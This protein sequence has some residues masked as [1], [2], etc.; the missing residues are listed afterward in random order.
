[1]FKAMRT[2]ENDSTGS[3]TGVKSQMA[4]IN[5]ANALWLAEDALK[6]LHT[7]LKAIPGQIHDTVDLDPDLNVDIIEPRE[8]PVEK[9]KSWKK[10][11]DRVRRRVWCGCI[12]TANGF[13]LDDAWTEAER[14]LIDRIEKLLIVRNACDAGH[15]AHISACVIRALNG[16]RW[17]DLY[18]F[19]KRVLSNILNNRNETL[20]KSHA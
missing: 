4:A 20:K 10:L 15:Y 14:A 8:L 3:T 11:P 2:A 7:N 16:S 9:L 13:S 18:S 6:N 12:W 19:C 5:I 1:M 17:E